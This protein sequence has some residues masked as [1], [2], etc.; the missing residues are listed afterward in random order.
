VSYT[1]SGGAAALKV[2]EPYAQNVID[3]FNAIGTTPTTTTT[4]TPTKGNKAT[5]T[6]TVP[7]EAHN[8]VGVDVLNASTVSGIAHSTGSALTNQGFVVN[9]VGDA[10]TNLPVGSSSEILYGPSGTEAAHT[11][12]SVLSGPVTLTPEASLSSSTVQLLIA[13]SSLSVTSSPGGTTS[14]TTVPTSTS[15]TIPGNV[16]A[17]KQP[18]PWNPSPCT[19][20]QSTQATPT[21][22]PAKGTKTAKASGT[23]TSTTARAATKK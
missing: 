7:T 22:K 10:P 13:G 14:T 23:T 3:A 11:L 15:T 9:E 8:L 1:S 19:L 20:G 18:E 4:T 5:T 16:Y 12:A 17:N 21:T 2:A 6:T